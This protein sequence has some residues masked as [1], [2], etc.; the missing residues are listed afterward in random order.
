MKKKQCL[1]LLI[2][3]LIFL[4]QYVMPTVYAADLEYVENRILAGLEEEK[5]QIELTALGISCQEL[6][7][8][9]DDLHYRGQWP[10][11]ME[12]YSYKYQ[13]DTQRVQSLRITYVEHDEQDR[14]VY[15][16][17]LARIISRTVYPGMSQWQ[18]AL[19]IHDYLAAH[20]AYDES[21]KLHNA[22]DMIDKGEGVCE[23][24][25]ML[26][27]DLLEM[28]GVESV[29]CHSEEM[30]HIWNLVKIN[31]VWYHVDLTWDDPTAD[32]IGRVMHNFFLLDDET[33]RDEEHGHYRWDF[34]EIA[35]DGE[36]MANGFWRDLTSQI[37]YE[38]AE[39]SY[40]RLDEG[41]KVGIFRRSELTGEATRL[42]AFDA[43]YV[44]AGAGKYH[45]S[46]HGLSLWDGRLYYSDMEHVYSIDTDGQDK[47][48]EYTHDAKK[49]GTYIAGS[50]VDDGV[51]YLTLSTHSQNFST[52]EIAVSSAGPVHAHSYEAMEVP[53]SCEV[54]GYIQY[55]CACGDSFSGKVIPA[56]G[57][58][59]DHGTSTGDGMI[60]YSC[61]NCDTIREE[62]EE[63]RTDFLNSASK[64]T[65]MKDQKLISDWK[66]LLTVI[67]LL[68]LAAH[69]IRNK[70]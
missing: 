64:P 47:R 5:D 19:S 9:M 12:T 53:A 45:Y 34:R 43:G 49:N 35:N 37:C 40:L 61:K 14:N 62:A 25:S 66:Q 21:L 4:L 22:Y 58:D 42:D 33:I 28:A 55:A 26:Y 56:T 8:L 29:L 3:L 57:H 15:D 50:M 20:Y 54:D 31:G 52:V 59:F 41:T 16:Q 39:V 48:V 67:L 27:Q 18:I 7:D 38:S 24:Y 32:C 63:N 69:F 44:D 6:E 11:Y 2:L 60:R 51:I 10:W 1:F 23:A 46:N 17:E 65:W 36:T 30:N 70:R 68:N 13:N